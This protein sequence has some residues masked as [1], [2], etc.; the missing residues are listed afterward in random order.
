M[1]YERILANN[2]IKAKVIFAWFA[3]HE[4]IKCGD[5]V[6]CGGRHFWNVCCVHVHVYP[7]FFGAKQNINRGCRHIFHNSYARCGSNVSDSAHANHFKRNFCARWSNTFFRIPACKKKCAYRIIADK[8]VRVRIFPTYNIYRH[9]SCLLNCLPNHRGVNRD[10][11]YLFPA[12]GNIV[13]LI[14]C[15]FKFRAARQNLTD[16]KVGIND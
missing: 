16:G 2:K 5:T 1:H 14:Q 8:L 13:S 12:R 9:R 6:S 11:G 15:A 3:S 4:V 10:S 7:A